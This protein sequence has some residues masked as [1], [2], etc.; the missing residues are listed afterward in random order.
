MPKRHCDGC[1][2]TYSCR[3]TYNVHLKKCKGII[4]TIE[5]KRPG[6]PPKR[7]TLAPNDDED[8]GKYAVS[9]DPPVTKKRVIARS[10]WIDTFEKAKKLVESGEQDDTIALAIM[11]DKCY[12]GYDAPLRQVLKEE[13]SK[14]CDPLR[15]R[16]YCIDNDFRELSGDEK[17]DMVRIIAVENGASTETLEKLKIDLVNKLF[18]VNYGLEVRAIHSK[19]KAYTVMLGVLPDE[20]VPESELI[21]ATS[22][23]PTDSQQWPD[24]T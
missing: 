19:M 1:D 13:Y 14:L 5:K 17:E 9:V 23:G 16:K 24:M 6:R 7:K 4:E 8:E 10:D 12:E 18:Y 2:K 15:E 22:L 20:V 11:H 3:Q 21:R